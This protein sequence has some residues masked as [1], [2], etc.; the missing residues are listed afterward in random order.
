MGQTRSFSW[1]VAPLAV[2]VLA[3][4][5]SVIIPARQTLRITALLRH[6]TEV[7]APARLVESA[8]RSGLAEEMGALR[9]YALAGD[10]ALLVRYRTIAA[11][12]ERRLESLDAVSVRL[13][14]A[15]ALEIVTV[16][17]RTDDWR[18]RASVI[19]ARRGSPAAFVAAVKA[20][21]PYYDAT[22]SAIDDLSSELAAEAITRDD[23]VRTLEHSS[24]VWN[25]ALVFAALAALYGAVLL[26]RRERRLAI[27]LR[28][29]I[30]EESSLRQLARALSG[31][32]TLDEAMQSTVAGALATARAFGAY[33]EWKVADGEQIDVVVAFSERTASSRTRVSNVDSLTAAIVT[34]GNAQ[35]LMEMGA[36]SERL[37]AHIDDS[38]RECFGLVAPLVSSAG[39]LVRSRSCARR[40][41]RRSERTNAG[42]SSSS[43]ISHQ[44]RCAV[45]MG[46]PPSDARLRTLDA[47]RG[48]KLRSGKPPRHSPAPS[49]STR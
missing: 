38:C 26:T 2:I 32:V 8:L 23:H 19:L 41:H 5:G 17:R 29:R 27:T 40:E 39:T 48:R 42:R 14:S 31:A 36:I 1:G 4:L 33:V 20:S 13:T 16:R 25:S 35:G 11:E 30:D 15:S 44:R 45:W 28:H 34:R 46:W 3:L 24:L 22:L 43:V 49:R 12:D 6:N 21:Q 37:L 47:A 9:G 18:Q 10:T 7:L